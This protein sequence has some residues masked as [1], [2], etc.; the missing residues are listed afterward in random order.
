[1]TRYVLP[2]LIGLM[3]LVLPHAAR[4]EGCAELGAGQQLPTLDNAKL[5]PRTQLLCNA[6]YAVLYSGLAREPLWSAEHLDAAMVRAAMSTPRRGEFHTDPR[7]APGEQSELEDYVRSGFDRGHMTPSGDMPDEQTQEETF[8]LSNIVPQRAALNRSRW[9]EIE[10]GVRRLTL[11]EG[12]LYVVT[13]PAFHARTLSAIGRDR[14]LVPTSTWKAVYDPRREQTGVY[15]C[16]NVSRA[17]GCSHVSV[18]ELTHITGIDPFPA[19]PARMK[20]VC[21]T[22]PFGTTRARSTTRHR[23]STRHTYYRWW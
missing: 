10:S 13:G 23:R 4:A 17:P 5:S 14:V 9:A 15:V 18:A 22:L 1:M 6:R 11:R 12:E 3:A 16:H 2:F 19:L 20:Q 7:I 8:L 21:M